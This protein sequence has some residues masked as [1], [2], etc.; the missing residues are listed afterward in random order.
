M[1]IFK[2]IWTFLSRLWGGDSSSSRHSS[3]HHSGLVAK[4]TNLLF[5][6]R[7]DVDGPLTILTGEYPKDIYGEFYVIYPVGSVNSGG[8]PFPKTLPDGS[9]NPEYGTPIMNGD[10][11]AVRISLSGAKPKLK[12]RLLKT[13]S[14]Y[15]DYASRYG[16]PYHKLF[17]FSNMGISR[18]STLLGSK[19]P[20]NTALTP[21]KTQNSN[22][23][24]IAGYDVGR[25]YII[26]PVSLELISPVGRGEE[27]IIASPDFMPWPFPFIQTTAHPSFDARTNELFIVNYSSHTYS[28]MNTIQRGRVPAGKHHHYKNKFLELLEEIKDEEIHSIR[29]KVLHFFHTHFGNQNA[30]LHHLM[31]PEKG[32]ALQLMRFT[33]KNNESMT[34]WMLHD[35]Y[36]KPI[37]IKEC[38]HQTALTKDYILLS[39]TSFKFSID[40]LIQNF[41]PNSPEVERAIRRVLAKPMLPYTQC[42]I[43]KR[44]DLEDHNDKA[45]AYRLQSPIPVETIHYSCDYENPDGKITMYGMQNAAMCIAEWIR[46]YDISK[47]TGEPVDENYISLFALGNMDISRLGKWVIDGEKAAIIEDESKEFVETGNVHEDNKGPNS[48]S[49]GLYAFPDMLSADVATSKIDRLWFVSNGLSNKTLTEFIFNLYKNYPNRK[50][51]VDEILK[52]TESEM[53]SCMSRLDTES[54]TAKDYYQCDPYVYFRSIQYVPGNP[55]IENAREFI[56]TTVQNGQIKSDGSVDYR[57]EYWIFDANNLAA[58]PICTMHNPDVAFCFTLHS[59]W[60]PQAKPNNI[61]YHIDIKGDLNALV[62]NLPEKDQI[63]DFFSKNVYPYFTR[64]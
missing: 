57:G 28:L 51:P 11:Y 62:K 29:G 35:Q 5:T 17:G 9:R 43:V 52:V 64:N 55:E 38:M 47:I 44:R 34:K 27:W 46:D 2:T 1:K 20:L 41:F 25:P 15:A 56:F 8:L 30:K 19:N 40:L 23:T 18:M 37:A 42:Y 33:G 22:T 26:D 50:I 16:T 14:Y 31:D 59:C 6:T 10:G 12:A 13:P 61:D 3:N 53:P 36:G 48:W 54:M 39:D 24:L 58:G 63:E 4:P 21:F 60:L 7:A 49:I 32:S 45:T